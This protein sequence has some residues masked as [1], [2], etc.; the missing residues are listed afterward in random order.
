MTAPNRSFAKIATIAVALLLIN[1]LVML[2]WNRL[3]ERRYK[4]ALGV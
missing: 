3:V 4:R 2:S 1:L